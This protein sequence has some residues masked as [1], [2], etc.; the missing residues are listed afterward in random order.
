MKLQKM[1]RISLYTLPDMHRTN[2]AEDMIR[3]WKNHICAIQAG[4]PKTYRLSNWCKDLEQVDIT[5]NM[6]CPCTQNPNLSASEAMDGMFSFDATPMAP[7][8]T[9]CMIHV[10]LSKRHTRGYH[11]MKAWYFAPALKHYCCI[12]VVTDA[13][14]V[15]ITDT[16][17]F[18]HHTLP[19]PTVSSTN[20]I[21]PRTFV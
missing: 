10:K 19:V 12:K 1:L 21:L 5:L 9:E 11:S 14:A 20:R 16:F 2:I 8:G 13:G 6:M 17:K 7:I 18:L 3:T 15:R 4:T